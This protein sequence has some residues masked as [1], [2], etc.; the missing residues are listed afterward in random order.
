MD[1]I[2]YSVQIN[3]VLNVSGQNKRPPKRP[4][5]SAYENASAGLVISPLSGV[6]VD[7][8]TAVP[9]LGP[10]M[11]EFVALN[12]TPVSLQSVFSKTQSLVSV[13]R[14]CA[15]GEFVS[16]VPPLLLAGAAPVN[17]PSW[18]KALASFRA[19]A[20]LPC[21]SVALALPV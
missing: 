5:V 6:S 7:S 16:S 10:L 20:I 3:S 4:V 12:V 1:Q 2:L 17:D 18:Y 13:G 19:A 21:A 8:R 14:S 9:P 11:V 15:Q